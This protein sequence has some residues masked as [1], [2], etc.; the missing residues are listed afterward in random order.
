METFESFV[1]GT[2]NDNLWTVVPWVL[3]AAGIYFGVRRCRQGP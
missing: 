3:I 2:I 1:T